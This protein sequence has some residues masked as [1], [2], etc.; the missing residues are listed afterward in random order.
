MEARDLHAFARR[1]LDDDPNACPIEPAD[2]ALALTWL[3]ALEV[4]ADL[5]ERHVEE[6]LAAER[7][8]RRT[9]MAAAF[10]QAS[11][12]GKPEPAQKP[13]AQVSGDGGE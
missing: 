7:Q 3:A 6:T 2:M 13:A 8:T 5:D 4:E 10:R 11:R 1:R 9:E 12:G